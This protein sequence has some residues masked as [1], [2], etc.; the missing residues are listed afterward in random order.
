MKT[1]LMIS[2]MTWVFILFPHDTHAKETIK[3]NTSDYEPYYGQN[4]PD[5]GPV[6]KV[7]V[8]AF[9]ESG[10]ATEIRFRPWARVISEGSHGECDAIACVW[11]NTDR[12]DWMA[13]TD[14]ILDNEVGFFKNVTD[15]LTFKDFSDLKARNVMV[16]VVRGY[17]NPEG[18]AESGVQTEEVGED[19]LNLRKL[20]ANRVR[21]TI[22]DKNMGLYLM[23]KEGK[24]AEIVWLTTLQR[25]PLRL[26]IMKKAQ[27]D[28]EK[29]RDDF[30]KGLKRLQDKGVVDQIFQEYDLSF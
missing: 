12:E 7:V 16:G 22:S 29:K 25:I 19:L 28:W 13:L 6:L 24:T 21:L 4:M 30:N 17:I 26:G 18:F 1:I 11:F 8:L 27:G 10:Y 2:A 23:K 3:I 9:A 20:V 15:D 14:P 5:Y